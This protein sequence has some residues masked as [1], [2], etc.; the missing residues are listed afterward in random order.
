MN[1]TWMQIIATLILAIPGI[2]ALILQFRRE[3]ADK[4]KIIKETEKNEV[5][6]KKIAN[7]DTAETYAKA[8]EIVGTQNIRLYERIGTLEKKVEDLFKAVCE[9]D[10]QI[11][12]LGDIVFQKDERILELGNII[13]SYEKRIKDLENEVELLRNKEEN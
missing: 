9:K 12:S 6:A 7:A 13:A 1:E 8:A 10:L 3:N 5:E 2:G 4:E 11:S